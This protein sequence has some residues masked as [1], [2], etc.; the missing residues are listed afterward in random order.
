MR[1]EQRG[2]GTLVIEPVAELAPFVP[3]LP[4]QLSEWARRD[5]GRPCL[6][7]RAGDGGPWVQYSFG[8]FKQAAD[9]VTQWLLNQ[10]VPSGRSLLVLSGNSIARARW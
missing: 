7:E 6:A 8:Q 5:P 10:R 1:V 3:N 4:V 2:D 9:A